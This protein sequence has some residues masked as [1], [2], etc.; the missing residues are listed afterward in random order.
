MTPKIAFFSCPSCESKNIGVISTH[1]IPSTLE[2][3]RYRKCRDCDHKWYS[4]QPPEIPVEKWQVE[5]S[6]DFKDKVK[7]LGTKL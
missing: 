2:T 3:V 7:I 4:V 6:Q 1:R 5:W